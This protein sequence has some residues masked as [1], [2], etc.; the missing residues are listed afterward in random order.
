[1]NPNDQ[2]QFSASSI[3]DDRRMSGHQRG[4]CDSPRRG[5]PWKC[6]TELRWDEFC[7]SKNNVSARMPGM[8]NSYLF[9]FLFIIS[10]QQESANYNHFSLQKLQKQQ[11]QF[12]EL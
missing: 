9:S 7:Q 11:D 5:S 10:V 4:R 12:F 2:V 1:M 8:N 3:C 6:I